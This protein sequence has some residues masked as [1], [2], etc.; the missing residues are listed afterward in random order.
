MAPPRNVRRR[1]ALADA[2]I[3]I[4]GTGGI[5]KL[6]HR[7]VDEQ[8]GLPQGT[9]SNYFP[10][11][12]DLLAAAVSRIGELQWAAMAAARRETAVS[13]G[14]AGP[15][16]EADLID[17]IGTFL[18]ESATRHRT[19]Y[20]A[21][22]ELTLESTRRPELAQ[23]IAQLV[24][25]ALDTTIAEHRALGLTTSP[26]QVQA[27]ISLYSGALLTSV[28]SPEGAFTHEGALALARCIV[29]GVLSDKKEARP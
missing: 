16:D 18:Y 28:I 12:D 13:V 27:L 2:A 4:L 6:S 29:A 24:G 22:F 26:E 1:E 25:V 23:A 19:R 20:L 8:A 11:R 3:E 5:H 14:V 15:V 21:V 10:R 17:L 9:A 7:A